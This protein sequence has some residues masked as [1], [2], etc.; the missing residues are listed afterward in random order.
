MRFL[1]CVL[2][3]LRYDIFSNKACPSCEGAAQPVNQ[4][5]PVRKAA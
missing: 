3:G 4:N 1:L 2:C 5:E